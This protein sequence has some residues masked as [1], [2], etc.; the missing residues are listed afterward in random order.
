MDLEFRTHNSKYMS[1]LKKNIIESSLNPLAW[2]F[3]LNQL[4]LD[5]MLLYLN[6]LSIDPVIMGTGNYVSDVA[7]IMPTACNTEIVNLKTELRKNGISPDTIWITSVEKCKSIPIDN[8]LTYLI[9]ELIRLDN[10]YIIV[11]DIISDEI[12]SKLTKNKP[13]L[14]IYKSSLDLSICSLAKEYFQRLK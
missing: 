4:Y 12:I 5:D 2:K 1:D 10:K 6:S 3:A 13:T 9:L 14:P 7:I 8:L 11:S